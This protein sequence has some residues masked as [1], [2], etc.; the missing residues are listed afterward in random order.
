MTHPLLT[1]LENVLA[2]EER[3]ARNITP[4]IWTMRERGRQ[5][6]A[7]IPD[8]VVDL[9]GQGVVSWTTGQSLDHVLAR[10]IAAHDPATVLA[11]VAAHRRLLT[12]HSPT[13]HQAIRYDRP[14]G[15]PSLYCP[16]CIDGA[17]CECC[18]VN[19]PDNVW[20]CNTIRALVSAFASR[21]GYDPAWG[22]T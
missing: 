10:H 12:L 14:H 1:W 15:E 18:P 9:P 17:P 16:T 6:L 2:E 19:H 13:T 8:Y 20:P 11:T 21:D 7:S 5:L 3:G 4:R 22:P